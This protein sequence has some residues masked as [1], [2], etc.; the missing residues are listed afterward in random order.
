MFHETDFS[1]FSSKEDKTSK[2][3][4]TKTNTKDHSKGVDNENF[5]SKENV[6][7]NGKNTKSNG[8]SNSIKEGNLVEIEDDDFLFDETAITKSFTSPRKQVTKNQLTLKSPQQKAIEVSP[9]K[10]VKKHQLSLRSPVK[11]VTRGESKVGESPL[12]NKKKSEPE[13]IINIDDD[14]DAFDFDDSDVTKTF[15]SPL[16]KPS[17]LRSNGKSKLAK[18]VHTGDT[19]T[20][21]I[22]SQSVKENSMTE[23]VFKPPQVKR[24][25]RENS[26]SHNR[27]PDEESPKAKRKS[28]RNDASIIAKNTELL[29]EKTL[30]SPDFSRKVVPET[31][32]NLTSKFD[33]DDFDSEPNPFAFDVPKSTTSRIIVD[34]TPEKIIKDTPMKDIQQDVSDEFN[35]TDRNDRFLKAAC[36]SQ[37]SEFNEC[38]DFDEREEANENF[39]ISKTTPDPVSLQT[40]VGER[41]ITPSYANK[42][43][44]ISEEFP[45]AKKQNINC[46]GWLT[47]TCKV[48]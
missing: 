1:N 44:L 29:T 40:P 8:T 48:M 32:P 18:N 19:E 14:D 35:D 24:K 5:S 46:D 17:N 7:A 3:K 13:N 27:T 20:A 41:L 47:T 36:S 37:A 43:T 21:T 33:D 30:I 6:D 4:D 28:K 15:D 31:A 25:L 16:R 26:E 45:I 2:A 34:D 9:P 22:V 11:R 42:D 23:D 39:E 38:V 10:Q 12:H